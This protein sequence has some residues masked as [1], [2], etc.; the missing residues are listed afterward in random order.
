MQPLDYKTVYGFNSFGTEIKLDGLS[1]S[2]YSNF[3][4]YLQARL[5]PTWVEHLPRLLFMRRLVAIP[6]MLY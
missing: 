5:E 2:V 1:L 6:Q 4:W 3:V